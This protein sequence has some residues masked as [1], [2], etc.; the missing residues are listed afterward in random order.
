MLERGILQLVHKQVRVEPN[1]LK[2]RHAID[3]F[4]SR[5]FPNPLDGLDLE[6]RLTRFFDIA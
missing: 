4:V 5:F 1:H 6:R 3:K 2:W